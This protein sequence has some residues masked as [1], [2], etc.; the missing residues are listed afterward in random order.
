[1]SMNINLEGTRKVKVLKTARI[2]EQRTKARLWQTPTDVTHKILKAENK[3]DVYAEWVMSIRR[4]YEENVYASFEDRIARRN[5][6]GTRVVHEGKDHLREIENWM[7]DAEAD[8][9]ELEFYMT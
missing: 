4:D 3:F 5:P 1:M 8:G 2:E 7:N 6:I 9:Y